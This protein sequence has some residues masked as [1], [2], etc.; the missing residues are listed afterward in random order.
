MTPQLGEREVADI[1]AVDQHAPARDVVQ[2]TGQGRQ[3]RLSRTREADEGHRLTGVQ[4]QVDAVEQ[5]ALGV[6]GILVPEVGVLE[7]EFAAGFG[8]RTGVLGVDDGVLLVEHLED[9][10]GRGARVEEEREQEADRLHRPPQHR[11]HRE[12]RDQ[13]GHLQL[14]QLRQHDARAEAHREGDVGQKNQPE[15]DPSDGAGFVDLGLAQRLGLAGELPERVRAPPE[16]L[17][18][19]D[20]VD[21]LFHGRGEVSGLVLALA[22]QRA[23]A[24]LEAEA[25]VDHGRRGD[26]EQRAEEPVPAEEQDGADGD[27]QHVDH[28][29]MT[30]KASQRRSILMSCIMRE[31]S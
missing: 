26:E 11:G 5:V 17:E 2:A 15:P 27:R 14:A 20:A 9:A 10:I 21:A 16:R 24:L 12:E 30:P 29:E 6:G 23:V 31:S 13:L 8:E 3:R 1:D 25:D 18:D 22:R 4:D 28:E 7:R 19:A